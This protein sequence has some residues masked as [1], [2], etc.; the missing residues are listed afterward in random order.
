MLI[1]AADKDKKKYEPVLQGK[2]QYYFILP[3]SPCLHFPEVP[4]DGASARRT[5]IVQRAENTK[6]VT[7]A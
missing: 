5:P 4:A 2:N 1:W 7:E 3:L 6:A